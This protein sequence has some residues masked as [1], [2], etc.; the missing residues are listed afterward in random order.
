M[1]PSRLLASVTWLA[2]S[3]ACTGTTV[4]EPEPQDL[5]LLEDAACSKAGDVN[6]ASRKFR[7][8]KTGDVA[9]AWFETVRAIHPDGAETWKKVTCGRSSDSHQEWQ[10]ST[11]EQKAVRVN[12]ADGGP[13][14]EV[15]IPLG[16]SGL[17]AHR[18][19]GPGLLVVP[20][21]QAQQACDATE[22]GAVQQLEDVKKKFAQVKENELGL[23]PERGGF[24][25]WIGPA[26]VHFEFDLLRDPEPRIR[27]W[28]DGDELE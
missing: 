10:C 14:L 28:D 21:A 26:A 12:P 1:R 11:T 5:R 20:R 19:V 7:Q 24:A 16:L 18:M 23:S 15:S 3:L 4:T 9:N 6:L 25:L 2:F 13:A 17:A 8:N 27:C 22:A